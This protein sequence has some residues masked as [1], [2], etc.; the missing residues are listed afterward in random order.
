MMRNGHGGFT[1]KFLA[2]ARNKF[3]QKRAMT[4]AIQGEIVRRSGELKEPL[5]VIRVDDVDGMI[6]R[7]MQSGGKIIT[8]RTEIAEIGMA[9]ASFE[10][11]EG[12]VVNIVGDM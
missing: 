3:T 2:G 7:I 9:F 5:L 10:D 1:G 12:N 11:T 8:Q 6:E 4:G